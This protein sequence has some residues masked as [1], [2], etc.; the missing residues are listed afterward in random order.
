MRESVIVKC[1]IDKVFIWMNVYFV[2]FGFLLCS[3]VGIEKLGEGR[4]FGM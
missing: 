3:R 1:F 4:V 2:E